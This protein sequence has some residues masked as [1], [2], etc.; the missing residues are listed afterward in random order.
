MKHG[1]A[2][3]LLSAILLFSVPL[4]AVDGMFQGRV[5]NAPASVARRAGWI[6]VQGRN[7]MLRRVEVAHAE[8]VFGDN[9]PVSQRHKC[10]FHCL[11]V[12]QE[13]RIIAEQDGQGEWRAKRVE[14]LRLVTN[15]AQSAE[16]RRT[17]LHA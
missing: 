8:I 9:I 2:R 14:I 7:H 11:E 12:G 16:A 3:I 15:R 10:N 5:V 4:L 1:G 13:V 6:F 17:A